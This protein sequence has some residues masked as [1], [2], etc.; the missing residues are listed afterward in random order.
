MYFW[1]K[2]FCGHFDKSINEMPNEI[3][4][5]FIVYGSLFSLKASYIL[6]IAFGEWAKR[7]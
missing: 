2:F 3:L 1:M 5:F 4:S 6:L 7:S